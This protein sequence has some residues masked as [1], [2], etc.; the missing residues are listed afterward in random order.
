[1]VLRSPY[2]ASVRAGRPFPR[3]W[4]LRTK[5]SIAA[6]DAGPGPLAT[7]TRSLYGDNWSCRI[8]VPQVE[9]IA[10]DDWF[11]PLPREDHHRR[12]DDIRGV[13]GA[14]EFPAGTGKLRVKGNDLNFL[15]P[16]ESP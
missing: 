10:G 12:V 2:M 14:A 4:R 7:P 8:K 6:R 1:M 16:Q 9:R 3:S 13:G 15:A 5:L 11:V